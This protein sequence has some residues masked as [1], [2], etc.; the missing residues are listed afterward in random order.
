MAIAL[1]VTTMKDTEATGGLCVLAIIARKGISP[2]KE[3]TNLAP[4]LT[5][6]AA[7]SLVKAAIVPDIIKKKAT[8]LAKV[9][10]SSVKAD[11]NSVKALISLALAITAKTAPTKPPRGE[12]TGLVTPPRGRKRGASVLTPLATILMQ[13]TA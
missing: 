11:T 2:A 3:A 5:V 12:A 6:K 7:I 9:G 10:I 8:S 1:R 13:S 4:D